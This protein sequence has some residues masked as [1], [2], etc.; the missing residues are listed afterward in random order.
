[1][2]K[3][4]LSK[5]SKR[6]FLHALSSIHELWCILLIAAS[7]FRPILRQLRHHI[8]TNQHYFYTEKR[9]SHVKVFSIHGGT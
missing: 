9:S 4:F 8:K 1:M 2:C 3:V 6:C 5:T 7:F